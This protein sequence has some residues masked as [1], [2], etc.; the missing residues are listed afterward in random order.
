MRR[1]PFSVVLA[2]LSIGGV[3]AGFTFTANNARTTGVVPL[4]TENV[5][6]LARPRTPN[7]GLPER[8]RSSASDLADINASRLADTADSRAVY[9]VPGTAGRICLVVSN[10]LDSSIAVTCAAR[11]L[12]VT[13][14]VLLSWPQP[15]GTENIIGV[16]GDGHDSVE[17]NGTTVKVTNNVFVLDHVK[18]QQIVF[19]GTNG[20]RQDFDIGVQHPTS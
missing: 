15:D 19:R 11:S 4:G 9:V 13:G 18:G 10:S 8:V 2:V 7:D 17:A 20:Q 5:S 12:L 3:L 16:V 6:L 14:S 1:R